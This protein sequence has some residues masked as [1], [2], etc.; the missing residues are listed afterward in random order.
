MIRN[1]WL[2]LHGELKNDQ[3]SDQFL[4]LLQSLSAKEELAEEI[5]QEEMAEQTE[6]QKELKESLKE[7]AGKQDFQNA[8]NQ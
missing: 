6:K 8:E 1:Y 3:L 4:Y 5:Y 7:K 2:D